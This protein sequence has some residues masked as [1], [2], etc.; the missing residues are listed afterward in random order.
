MSKILLVEDDNDVALEI[1]EYLRFKRMTVERV[2]TINAARDMILGSHFDV[3][4]MDWHLPDGTGVD[5]L[6]EI[7][8]AR[9]QG[10]VLM[11][12]QRADVN[13]KVT[14]FD[15]GADDYLTKPFHTSELLCRIQALLRRPQRSLEVVLVAGDLSLNSTA[16]TVSKGGE[17]IQ[18]RP[19]EFALLEF[20][21]RHPN[22]AFSLEALLERVWEADN[23]STTETVVATILRLRKKIDARGKS[24]FIENIWG[25]GYKFHDVEPR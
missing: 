20:F 9:H 4:V 11:L 5:L 21:M 12:T 24:S 25:V 17:A 15:A 6:R 18:L 3:V 1:V 16:R 19:K 2:A 14:G 13:D 7:R 22:E 8:D 10:A 23:E